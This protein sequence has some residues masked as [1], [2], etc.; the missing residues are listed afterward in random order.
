MDYPLRLGDFGS[1]FLFGVFVRVA[2]VLV[3]MSEPIMGKIICPNELAFI[4]GRQ[5]ADRIVVVLIRNKN[6]IVLS[7]GWIWGRLMTLLVGVFFWII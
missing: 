3:E 2:K 5:L 6:E 7:L 1:I 4:K